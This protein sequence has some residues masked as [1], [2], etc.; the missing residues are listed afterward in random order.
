[1]RLLPRTDIR[2]VYDEFM[3]NRATG[4]VQLLPVIE[5]W[6]VQ[7]PGTAQGCLDRDPAA[8]LDDFAA[9]IMRT[10]RRRAAKRRKRNR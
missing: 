2:A 1:M 6:I 8:T 10:H 9:A 7:F 3:P 4:I 5:R